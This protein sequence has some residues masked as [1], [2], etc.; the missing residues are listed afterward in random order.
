VVDPVADAE[1]CAHEYG[2]V[3]T[4]LDQVIAA[5][6]AILAVAHAAFRHLDLGELRQRLGAGGPVLDVKS[7]LDRSAVVANGLRLWRL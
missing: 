5:E 2:I 6:A 3:P 4:S 1:A 7:T